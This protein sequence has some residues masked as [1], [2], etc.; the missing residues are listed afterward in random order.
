M[1]NAIL[2][3]K[4]IKISSFKKKLCGKYRPNHFEGGYLIVMKI[5]DFVEPDYVYFGD[6]DYQQTLLIKYIIDKR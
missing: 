1:L 2:C 4:K 3:N 5:F 6:K